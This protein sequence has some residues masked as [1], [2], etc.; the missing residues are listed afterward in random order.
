[1]LYYKI[2]SL[3]LIVIELHSLSI[4]GT[5]VTVCFSYVFDTDSIDETFLYQVYS[6]CFYACINLCVWYRQCACANGL[7]V[8]YSG[9]FIYILSLNPRLPCLLPQGS[10]VFLPTVAAFLF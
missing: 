1:M 4:I 8:L 9:T 3:L 7:S 6:L 2:S 10:L 5:S